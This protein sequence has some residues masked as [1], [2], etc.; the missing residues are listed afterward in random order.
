MSA[1]VQGLLKKKNVVRMV[2]MF[3][4]MRQGPV[5][6]MLIIHCSAG[7]LYWPVY[8]VATAAA[9]IASQATICATFSLIKQAVALGCF[10]RVKVVH[11]SKEFLN[12]IYIPDVN[13]IL[14]ILCVTVTAGFKDQNQIGNASGKFILF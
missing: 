7:S 8:V 9:I 3:H 1:I 12:R 4:S 13:W 11:T 14:M 10:P 6:Q 5:S 2:W